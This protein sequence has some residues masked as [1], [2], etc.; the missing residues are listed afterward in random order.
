VE[1]PPGYGLVNM[2]CVAQHEWFSALRDAGF[3]RLE[4]LYIVTR[5]SVESARLEWCDQHPDSGLA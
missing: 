2:A 1:T 4:A 3:S 5:P